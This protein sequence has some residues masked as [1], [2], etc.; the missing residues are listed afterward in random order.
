[1]QCVQYNW[2]VL[3][4]GQSLSSGFEIK[5]RKEWTEKM[6]SCTFLLVNWHIAKYFANVTNKFFRRRDIF[7]DISNVEERMIIA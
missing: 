4:P 1:V 6:F 3:T 7:E 5:F 2:R